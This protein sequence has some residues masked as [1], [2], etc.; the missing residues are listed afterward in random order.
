MAEPTDTDLVL[1]ALADGDEA[2]SARDE[3]IHRYHQKVYGFLH[4]LTGRKEDAEDLTQDTF[5]LAL[6]KLKTFKAGRDLLPWLFTIARRTAISQWRKSKP[7][8]PLFDSDH[9]SVENNK[10]HDA[11]VLWQIAK[12]K[13][14]PD[15]FTALWMHYQEDLP[16][17]EVARVLKKTTTHAKVIVYRARKRLG[18][19]LTLTN[20]TW[21][22]GQQVN[23]TSP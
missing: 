1:A 12:D 21:L 7:T 17:K 22:P 4:Q 2:M 11:V 3:I 9:P 19:E 5:L 13:L 16:I 8:S 18:K 15:E 23:L 6:R 10:P 14:K 20:D